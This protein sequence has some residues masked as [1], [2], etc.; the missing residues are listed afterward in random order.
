MKPGDKLKF[1][2]LSESASKIKSPFSLG[3][4]S[5]FVPG[6]LS[7]SLAGREEFVFL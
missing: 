3:L 4:F 6:W 1:I 7:G 2:K 5:Q